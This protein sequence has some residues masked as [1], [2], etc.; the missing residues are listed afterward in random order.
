MPSAIAPDDTS[1]ISL[2]LRR[3]RGDLLGPAADG[4]V[5][6]AASFVGDQGRSDLDHQ[7]PRRRDDRCR[8][9]SR[10]WLCGERF[11]R[12][13]FQPALDGIDELAAAL[14]ADRGDREHRALPSVRL[15]ERGDARVALV[16]R[17][18]DRACSAPASAAFRTARGRS[19][20]SSR[21]IARASATGS[22]S[23]SSGARST[24]CSSR[25]VRCRWRRNWWPSPAPSAAPS[26]SPGMS[27]TTKLRFSSTR[28]TPRFGA[29]VVNG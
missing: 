14:A 5:I 4:V 26:I 19:A 23:P 1:T 24:T 20:S 22:A 8:A 17:R 27:A 21:T 28:T 6:D 12:M 10:S 25:R 18:S 9:R 16:R 2:P 3:Q 7:P 15:D 11:G 29:S 13:R